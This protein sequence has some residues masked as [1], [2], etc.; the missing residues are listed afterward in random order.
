MAVMITRIPQPSIVLN[1]SLE[2]SISAKGLSLETTEEM[3]TTVDMSGLTKQQ[4]DL[5]SGIHPMAA[6][7]LVTMRVP[8]Q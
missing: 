6:E 5:T 4:L 8:V 1:L 7:E 3:A 2:A